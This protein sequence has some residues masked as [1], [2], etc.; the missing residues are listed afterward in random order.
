[1]AASLLVSHRALKLGLVTEVVHFD[2][3]RICRLLLEATTVEQA[4]CRHPLGDTRDD[5]G[6]A[7][8]TNAVA[9][10]ECPSGVAKRHRG[11][12]SGAGSANT[13]GEN[14]APP[15]SVTRA[16]SG[17]ELDLLQRA[18][19][20]LLSAP[21]FDRKRPLLETKLDLVSSRSDANI[22][23]P[24]H[25]F[26]TELPNRVTLVRIFSGVSALNASRVWWS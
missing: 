20:Q 17:A 2:Q 8:K 16:G 13:A 6:S 15:S 25:A 19:E 23:M 18:I 1:M 24:L 22:R 14:G 9:E 3:T 10:A 7:R 26:D 4:E 21:L 11:K 12:T 5:Y